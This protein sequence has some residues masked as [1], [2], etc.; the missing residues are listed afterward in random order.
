MFD[1]LVVSIKA[2]HNRFQKLVITRI[3]IVCN[4]TIESIYTIKDKIHRKDVVTNIIFD[5]KI[6]T[7]FRGLQTSY[8][9]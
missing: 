1:I 7:I 5:F 2:Y 4:N 3:E 6:R 9:Y 8:Y